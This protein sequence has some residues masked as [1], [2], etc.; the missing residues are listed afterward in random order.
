MNDP[1]MSRA[2]KFPYFL[3]IHNTLP[4]IAPGSR[5]LHFNSRKSDFP[6]PPPFFCR[7]HDVFAKPEPTS[8]Q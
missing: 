6:P 8:L 7:Q 4:E 5:K 2:C 3:Q 1:L